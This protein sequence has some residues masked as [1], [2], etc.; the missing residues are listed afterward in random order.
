MS[1]PLF[2]DKVSEIFVKGD[3]FCNLFEHEFTNQ[4][5]PVAGDLQKCNR[6]TTITDSEIITILIAFH[7]GQFRNFKPIYL[8]YLCVHL[9]DCFPGVVSY[10]GL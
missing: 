4:A 10:N 3:D 5:L 6:K 2:S 1:T 7:G 9:R 8:G